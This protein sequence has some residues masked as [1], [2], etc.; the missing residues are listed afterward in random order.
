LG[1]FVCKDF[2][3]QPWLLAVKMTQR[4]HF[5]QIFNLL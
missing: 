5:K 1:F 3:W 4:M 2:I